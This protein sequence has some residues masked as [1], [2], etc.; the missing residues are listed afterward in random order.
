APLGLV[1]PHVGY[2]IN[3]VLNLFWALLA[4]LGVRY[5]SR[6]NIWTSVALTIIV[7]YPGFKGSIHLGQNAALTLAIVTWGWALI[8]RDRPI[9]GGLVWGFL[10]FKP[11]WAAA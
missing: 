6:A 10:A 4:A 3:Q 9:P 2:R 8:V 1:E 5:L 7:L 11:V